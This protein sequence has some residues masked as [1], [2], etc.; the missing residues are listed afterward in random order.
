MGTDLCRFGVRNAKGKLTFTRD[1]KNNKKGLLQICQS[2]NDSKE[3]VYT[4]TLG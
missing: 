2:E 4:D 1:T 3:S